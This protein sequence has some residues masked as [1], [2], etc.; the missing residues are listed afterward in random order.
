[1]H[2][3]QELV[4]L[5][6]QIS[7]QGTG[8]NIFR[9]GC[10]MFNC[11]YGLLRFYSQLALRLATR[12][13]RTENWLIATR[14]KFCCA[15]IAAMWALLCSS[16]AA[17]VVQGV[18]SLSNR[19]LIDCTSRFYCSTRCRNSSERKEEKTRQARQTRHGRAPIRGGSG[20]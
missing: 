20:E 19:F 14:R 1:M 6:P 5:C 16:R 2:L 18:R 9:G 7:V 17:R 10:M 12:H 11:D 8:S 15:D 13:T 4:C 3:E